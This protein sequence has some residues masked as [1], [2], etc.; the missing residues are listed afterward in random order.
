MEQDKNQGRN[1]HSIRKLILVID[2][3]F[4]KIDEDDEMEDEEEKDSIKE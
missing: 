2:S 3:K 4:K 1:I